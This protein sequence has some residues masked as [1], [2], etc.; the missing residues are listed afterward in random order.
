MFSTTSPVVSGAGRGD[1]SIQPAYFTSSLFV[2]PL[3]EDIADLVQEF[4]QQLKFRPEAR[5]FAVFKSLWVEHGWSWLHLKVLEP[6]AREMF[7]D[8]VLR[9]FLGVLLPCYI[10]AIAYLFTQSR[11]AHQSQS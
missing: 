11:R 6:R 3:R 9:L 7:L 2:N 8:V 4:D 1:V 10:A 5:P